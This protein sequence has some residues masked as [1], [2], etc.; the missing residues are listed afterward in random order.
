M[1]CA[2]AQPVFW[3]GLGSIE[4]SWSNTFKQDL[5]NMDRDWL[6]HRLHLQ[7][8]WQTSQ[9]PIDKQN[10]HHLICNHRI[11]FILPLIS[12][13]PQ[14]SQC[15]EICG[16]KQPTEACRA[17]SRACTCIQE[18]AVD[19]LKLRCT[20]TVSDSIHSCTTSLVSDHMTLSTTRKETL[21]SRIM[22]ARK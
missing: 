4:T 19:A 18:S 12:S 20:R 15:R 8:Q 3:F 2:Q 10:R 16:G 6:S 11:F 9:H 22:A 13:Q 17:R 21:P 5:C 7:S 14:R 1:D